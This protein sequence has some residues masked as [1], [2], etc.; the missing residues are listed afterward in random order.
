MHIVGV[1]FG[2]M[3][4]SAHLLVM[5]CWMSTLKS[6]HMVKA[7]GGTGREKVSGS[8]LKSKRAEV[9]L[10]SLQSSSSKGP[11][12]VPVPGHVELFV[13]NEEPHAI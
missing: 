8:Q 11:D 4:V 1:V 12:M 5:W 13:S 7:H 9:R 3:L 6:L 10:L 2:L